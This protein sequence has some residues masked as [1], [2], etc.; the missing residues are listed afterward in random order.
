MRSK[1]YRKLVENQ[2]RCTVALDPDLKMKAF[3]LAKLLKSS[4]CDV[5]VAFAP[6]GKDFGEMNKQ[7]VREALSTAVKYCDIMR[8]SHKISRMSSGSVI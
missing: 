7:Q 3:K 6:E 5:E 1:L 2:A 8:I 4:G